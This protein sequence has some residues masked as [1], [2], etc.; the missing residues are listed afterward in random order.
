RK[1]VQRGRPV[2]CYDCIQCAEGEISNTTDSNDCIQCP[3]DYW[4]NENRDECVIKIIEFLSFEEIMGILLMI[5]SLAGAFLTICIALV[6]L[7][8]KD[9]PIVKANN[10]ELSFLLLFSLTLCF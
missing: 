3:L 7:K 2:C 4:S 1:A 8:Y 10:S 9:S 5:F 6:F